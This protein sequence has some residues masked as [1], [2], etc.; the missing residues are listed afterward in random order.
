MNYEFPDELDF[1]ERGF[2]YSDEY[3]HDEGL[4]SFIMQ[5]DNGDSLAFTH[6]P[7]YNCFIRVR[8]VQGDVVIFDVYKENVT[9]ITF[10]TWGSE[11]VLRVHFSKEAENNDFLL[12]FNPKP[13]LCYSEL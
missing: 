9:S 11:K 7:L 13:R 1:F 4:F 5:Y 3:N 8:L 6:S 12:Y 10:Q 2:G